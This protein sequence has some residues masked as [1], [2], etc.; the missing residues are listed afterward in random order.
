ML[1]AAHLYSWK[2]S[3]T[4]ALP[5]GL[6]Q[7]RI[8]FSRGG[9]QTFLLST[10]LQESNRER[11]AAEDPSHLIY[12]TPQLTSDLGEPAHWGLVMQNTSGRVFPAR[13]WKCVIKIWILICINELCDLFSSHILHMCDVQLHPW[14]TC[15]KKAH[16]N[17]HRMFQ[18][19]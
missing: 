16:S 5:Q 12:L 18:I 10:V 17:W 15:T 13:G 19:F 11:G 9:H 8:S 2:Q 6:C 1:T 14:N 3:S 4:A 7:M